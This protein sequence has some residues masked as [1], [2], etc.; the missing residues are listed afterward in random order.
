MDR[1]VTRSMENRP[2][3]FCDTGQNQIYLPAKRGVEKKLG[4]CLSCQK[5]QPQRPGDSQLVATGREYLGKLLFDRPRNISEG[6]PRGLV[7]VL[8]HSF[9]ADSMV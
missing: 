6:P 8:V 7:E 2:A 3:S 4:R 9:F 1:F 5:S